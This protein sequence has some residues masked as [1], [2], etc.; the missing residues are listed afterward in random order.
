MKSLFL[1]YSIPSTLTHSYVESVCEI[2]R[3]FSR[4]TVAISSFTRS[5]NGTTTF[6]HTRHKVMSKCYSSFSNKYK[7]KDIRCF[8]E[9]ELV[10]K[11]TFRG[12]DI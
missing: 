2:F 4:H 9:I 5:R 3:P 8:R 7:P 6:S 11:H 1:F 10:P 12:L